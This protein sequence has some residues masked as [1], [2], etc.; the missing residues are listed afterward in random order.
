MDVNSN[1]EQ[2]PSPMVPTYLEEVTC[3]EC[4]SRLRLA[5]Q[6][7][8]TTAAVPA[9]CPVCG[10]ALQY[11]GVPFES[12]YEYKLAGI[13]V[14]ER[15]EPVSIVTPIEITPVQV[16]KVG[17]EI[18]YEDECPHCGARLKMWKCLTCTPTYMQ[19]ICPLCGGIVESGYNVKVLEVIAGPAPEEPITI[20][21]E[22]GVETVEVEIAPVVP[23]V[24]P[25][26]EEEAEAAGEEGVTVGGREIPWTW[27]AIGVLVLLIIGRR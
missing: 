5:W 20:E 13:Q 16:K 26:D 10:A 19:A 15:V 7:L 8:T 4:G 23:V 24:E 1:A 14:L 18:T 25:V 3:P 21:K 11:E 2:V 9:V 22:V 6:G 12:V 17:G 27:I